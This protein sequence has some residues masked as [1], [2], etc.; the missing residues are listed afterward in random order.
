M[1]MFT[2]KVKRY[3]CFTLLTKKDFR[4]QLIGHFDYNYS[5]SK[6]AIICLS[7]SPY[8]SNKEIQIYLI[9]KSPFGLNFLTEA[10]KTLVTR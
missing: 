9:L 10:Y 8:Q 1:V 3:K 2:L 5:N 7:T 6:F 4:S